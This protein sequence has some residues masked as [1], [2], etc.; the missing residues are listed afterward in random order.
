MEFR[1]PM[2]G[3][4]GILGLRASAHPPER[5]ELAAMA[6]SLA[7]R[8]PDGNGLHLDGRIGLAH[9]RLAIIDLES[10][11]QPIFNE[12]RSVAV[13]FNG[14]IFNHIELRA[15][16]E[17]R[18]HRF[19]TRSDTE[20]LVHLYEDHGERF[21]EHLNG[22]FAIALWDAR[23]E[24]LVLARD[25]AGIRPLFHAEAHGRFVFASE[26]KALFALPEVPRA[27]DR[28]ALAEI[29]TYWSALPPRSAFEGVS[30]LPP[31]HVMVIA[32]GERRLERYWDW[33]FPESSPRPSPDEEYAEELRA[34]LVDSVR[35]QLRADVPVGSYLSG[36][37]DS[38]VVAALA[39]AGDR[40]RL[41]TFSLAFEDPEFDES[42]HQRALVDFL[43]TAHTT[44]LGRRGDIAAAFPRAIAHAESTIVRT[45]PAPLMLLAGHVRD[46]GYKVV[47][48]GEGADEVFAGYDLFKEA[49]VRRFW[50]RS[51]GSKW[52]PRLLERL[53]P[54][55]RHSPGSTGALAT[56]YFRDSLEDPASPCFAH[57]PRWTSTRRIERFFSAEQRAV[58]GAWDAEAALAATLPDD[59]GRWLPLG[60]DQYVE[61][62]TLMSG[63]LLSSQGD[64]MAMAHSVEG[65]FPYLD[66]RVIEFANRLPPRLKL[67][68]LTEKYILK[69]AAAA[70]VPEAVRARAKQPYRAPDSQSFFEGGRPAGYVAE[71]FSP[72][73]IAAAGYFDP[74]AA[75]RLLEKCR[76]GRALGFADNMAFVAI[77]STMLLHEQLVLGRAVD[78]APA[79]A[80]VAA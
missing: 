24:R 70:W 7:H 75:S 72:A 33:S 53:Y 79:P 41:R 34:L 64:R 11:D 30:T 55:M 20:V 71:L 57:R 10:G 78:A 27:L 67:R 76:A 3:I 77:L 66:H 4:A 50:S 56:A 9:A 26:V 62:H 45:A 68:G 15:C 37:L 80:T 2:C 22:Q 59:I 39:A 61:A 1:P 18:G 69:K 63:Y 28:R 12:D 36:G 65:R 47:L 38:A 52:R 40:S 8:G 16:L 32:G 58:V 74:T 49:C 29:C 19:Y 13:V 73:R 23:R 46:S 17:A 21:V 54:W 42:A 5:G 25:R 31:G 51:P 44:I 43:G 6:S 14:E 35:L 48:T 60:R